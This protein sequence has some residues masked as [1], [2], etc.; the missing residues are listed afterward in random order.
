MPE[1][2]GAMQSD[3]HTQW[4]ERDIARYQTQWHYRLA[5]PASCMVYVIFAIPLSLY[6]TRRAYGGTMALTIILAIHMVLLSSVALA[7]GESGNMAPA[8]SAWSPV[9]VFACIG[10]WLMWRRSSGR[11]LWPLFGR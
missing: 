11:A 2:S 1:L 8:L 3:M 4:L 5:L 7:L 9:M 6:V 10:C